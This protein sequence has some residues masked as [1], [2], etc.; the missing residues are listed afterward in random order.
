MSVPNLNVRLELE[1]SVRQGDGMGG[2]RTVWQRIG[3]LWAEMKAG[4]NVF[5]PSIITSRSRHRCSMRSQPW[6]RRTISSSRTSTSSTDTKFGLVRRLRRWESVKL[7]SPESISYDV[8]RVCSP[9]VLLFVL[10]V[11]AVGS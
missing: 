8:R 11:L 9:A 10:R 5:Q 4:C 2:Y 7:R 3:T 1:G 6:R